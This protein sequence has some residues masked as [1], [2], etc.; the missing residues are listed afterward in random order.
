MEDRFEEPRSPFFL[1]YDGTAVDLYTMPWMMKT[2]LR[3]MNIK[4]D[5]SCNVVCS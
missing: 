3:L 5:I 1:K 4:E 2:V